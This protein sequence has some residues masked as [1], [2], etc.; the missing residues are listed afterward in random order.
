[1]LIKHKLIQSAYCAVLSA[2]VLLS[3]FLR[4]KPCDLRLQNPL[5]GTVCLKLGPTVQ[6]D[7][8]YVK[9]RT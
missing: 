2:L 4:E 5:K 9:F 7:G 8:T 3:H 6:E 1:M